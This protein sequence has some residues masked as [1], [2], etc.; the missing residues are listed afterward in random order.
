VDV[1]DEVH[2]GKRGL[3]SFDAD[4]LKKTGLIT[5]KCSKTGQEFDFDIIRREGY[6][7]I[8]STVV[9]GSNKQSE[10]FARGL[11]DVLE[12]LS[13]LSTAKYVSWELKSSVKVIN[14]TSDTVLNACFNSRLKECCWLHVLL[15][16]K[17]EAV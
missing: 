9:N 11:R 6:D 12:L 17:H 10:Q 8:M 1:E 16:T 3:L 7:D 2:D 14:L 4:D 13:P 15:S 5:S